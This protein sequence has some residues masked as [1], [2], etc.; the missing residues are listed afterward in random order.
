MTHETAVKKYNK[1]NYW[2]LYKVKLLLG[3]KY[4]RTNKICRECRNN[5]KNIKL[6]IFVIIIPETQ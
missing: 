6:I 5:K 1:Y 4:Y 2:L 3:H